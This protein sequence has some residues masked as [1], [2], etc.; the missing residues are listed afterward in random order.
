MDDIALISIDYVQFGR[1]ELRIN[2]LSDSPVESK[3]VNFLPI[4]FELWTSVL[5]INER[6][7]LSVNRVLE[8]EVWWVYD[9]WGWLCIY[10]W[11]WLSILS[12]QTAP[13][14]WWAGLLCLEF[15]YEQIFG[16]VAEAFL[17]LLSVLVIA[18]HVKLVRINN[19]K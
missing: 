4:K 6:I 13:W 8:H 19:T 18:D 7:N 10:H 11:V 3:E 12:V 1:P 14:T 5:F 15:I 9:V 16:Q 17:H 2:F